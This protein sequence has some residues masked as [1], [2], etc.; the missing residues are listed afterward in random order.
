MD[1]AFERLAFQQRARGSLTHSQNCNFS[2]LEAV[3]VHTGHIALSIPQSS[4]L[5]CSWNLDQPTSLFQGCDQAHADPKRVNQR[6]KVCFILDLKPLIWFNRLSI[7]YLYMSRCNVQMSMTMHFWC[8]AVHV[9]ISVRAICAIVLTT[10]NHKWK[11][12]LL[13]LWESRP[14]FLQDGRS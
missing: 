14:F 3:V 9:E 1:F 13:T 5:T 11:E 2:C 4:P 10:A 12:E 8:L 6:S 7:W